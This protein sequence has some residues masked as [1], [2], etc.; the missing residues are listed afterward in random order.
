MGKDISGNK[1]LKSWSSLTSFD[2]SLISQEYEIGVLQ[3]HM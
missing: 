1:P 3:Y 2:L